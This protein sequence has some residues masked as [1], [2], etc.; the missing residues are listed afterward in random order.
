MYAK[1]V[2]IGACVADTLISLPRYPDENT[3]QKA[4]AIRI[5]GGGPTAT[6]LVAAAKLDVSSAFIGNLAKDSYGQF[7]LADFQKYKV[8]ISGIQV[9]SGYHSFNSCIW[10]GQDKDT[11]TCVFDRGDLL[12]L[13]LTDAQCE[14][15]SKAEILMVDGNELNAAVKAAQAAKAAGTT[16][17]YDAGGL[18]EGVEQL[19]SLTDILIPSEEFAMG[20][21]SADTVEQAAEILA[22]R[23]SPKVVVIT[24][25]KRGGLLYENG[26][27][28]RYPIY[29]AD[30]LDSNGAGD[31]FH[32]AFAAGIVKGYGFEQCCHYASAVSALKCT[33][34][35]ARESAP[36]HGEVIRFLRRNG[37]EF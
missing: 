26:K 30:V 8:D 16:V 25:G 20:H 34:F 15:I 22:R 12:P 10:L 35:G 24:Q 37:Y 29:P 19:L 36:S 3:K 17:L 6:G 11:R 5:C 4:E 7:L 2:G 18:Y 23:Y 28:L 32:G 21:T 9:L 14:K 31:V 27:T 1:I 33:G 13:I